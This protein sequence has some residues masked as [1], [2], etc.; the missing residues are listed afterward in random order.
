MSQAFPS[1]VGCLDTHSAHQEPGPHTFTRGQLQRARMATVISGV[2]SS[3]A[4]KATK[5]LEVFDKGKGQGTPGNQAGK[6][7]K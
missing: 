7:Q 1:L 6:A 5:D 2:L 3:A 4:S